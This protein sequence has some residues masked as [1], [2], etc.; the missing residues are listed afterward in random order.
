MHRST[1]SAV[2]L[3][4]GELRLIRRQFGNLGIVWAIM[5]R[6][7]DRIK[8]SFTAAVIEDNTA[9][10][11]SPVQLLVVKQFTTSENAIILPILSSHVSS[12][13]S[14]S[15]R[16]DKQS[17]NELREMKRTRETWRVDWLQHE[18]CP[19]DVIAASC[20]R[21]LDHTDNMAV[22]AMHSFRYDH[23]RRGTHD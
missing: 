10:L 19:T 17:E 14:S 3:R 21:L 22:N 15:R 7:S 1:L 18:P 9:D 2:C 8:S 11:G 6:K 4:F 23:S 12:R 13:R 20:S 16:E 5:G